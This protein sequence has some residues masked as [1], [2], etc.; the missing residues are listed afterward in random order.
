MTKSAE[1]DVSLND[2]LSRV[3][4]ETGEGW[5]HLSHDVRELVNRRKALPVLYYGRM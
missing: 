1:P 2:E 3:L 5:H 4:V